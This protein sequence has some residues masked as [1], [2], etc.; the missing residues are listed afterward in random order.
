M[1]EKYSS[2]IKILI[3]IFII[4]IIFPT[5]IKADAATYQ[6]KLPKNSFILSLYANPSTSE[7]K[8]YRNMNHK[9]YKNHGSH[10]NHHKKYINKTKRKIELSKTILIII[11]IVIITILIFKLMKFNKLR[12]QAKKEKIKLEEE[13][14]YNQ[15]KNH[16]MNNIS[17][18]FRTPLNVISS[19]TQLLQLYSK[20]EEIAL[21]DLK[22]SG[23][24][25]DIHQNSLRLLRLINNILDISALDD[26]SLI[27]DLQNY[28][29]VNVIEN[30]CTFANEYIKFKEI[31]IIFDTDSE[32]LFALI[33]YNKFEKIILN[34]LSNAIKFTPNKMNVF[35]NIT[36]D[37]DCIY[38]SI[39]DNGIGISK[40]NQTYIFDKFSQVDTSLSRN[41]EGSGLGL[42]LVKGLINLHGGT[43]SLASQLNMGSTFTI[44]LP[45]NNSKENAIYTID[46]ITK[47]NILNSIN[48]EFSDIYNL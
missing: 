41:V 45:I 4:F 10:R 34:L 19:G 40:E 6:N 5:S 35:V 37:T 7:C 27:L 18:E 23:R 11:F 24:I 13:L 25:S 17:H 14:K 42:F 33:D 21:N 15:L 43:I 39:S 32:E 20:S 30:L 47:S 9:K 26:S 46:E 22:V 3:L 36:H 12:H 1:K 44:S 2:I 8:A 28:N 31:S 29:V 38:I 48:I 16:F